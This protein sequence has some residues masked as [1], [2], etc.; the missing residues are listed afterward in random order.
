MKAIADDPLPPKSRTEMRLTKLYRR[1]QAQLDTL[2]AK[3]AG[4]HLTNDDFTKHLVQSRKICGHLR[5]LAHALIYAENESNSQ[6]GKALQ[7]DI[8][9]M[10]VGIHIRLL[11]LDRKVL[12]EGNVVKTEIAM[13]QEMVKE[14]SDLLSS[15]STRKG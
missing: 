10:M 12:I 1:L 6:L 15:R 7:D 2:E 4:G 11:N 9:Q 3:K 5:Q 8:L 13:I 14:S